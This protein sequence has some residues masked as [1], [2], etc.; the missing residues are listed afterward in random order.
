MVIIQ[1]NTATVKFDSLDKFYVPVC[2]IDSILQQISIIFVCLYQM[3]DTE[4]YHTLISPSH[5]KEMPVVVDK[6][7]SH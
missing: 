3:R 5:T 6:V 4:T 1:G 2:L 7:P